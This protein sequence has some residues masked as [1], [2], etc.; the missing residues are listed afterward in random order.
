MSYRSEP[1]SSV[2]I[3]GTNYDIFANKSISDDAPRKC[4]EKIF[5]RRASI[6]SNTNNGTYEHPQSR[7]L[8][9]EKDKWLLSNVKRGDKMDF[10]DLPYMG[11]W[12]TKVDSPKDETKGLTTSCKQDSFDSLHDLLYKDASN[13]EVTCQLGEDTSDPFDLEIDQMFELNPNKELMDPNV[14]RR[15]QMVSFIEAMEQSQITQQRIQDWDRKMGLK[16]SHSMTMR[17]SAQS[18]KKLQGQLGRRLRKQGR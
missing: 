9:I 1:R 2:F 5:A 17:L 18:R 11:Y 8:S 13:H 6:E 10:E 3:S 16:R 15:L 14:L 7:R 4:H 12:K